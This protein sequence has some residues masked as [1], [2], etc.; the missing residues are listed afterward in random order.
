MAHSRNSY[1]SFCHRKCYTK[2]KFKA[3]S[4]LV[5][6]SFPDPSLP[7]FSLAQFK[8]KRENEPK[9]GVEV[10]LKVLRC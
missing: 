3:A 4:L 5:R 2:P 6:Y 8:Y 10:D 7:E 1:C 9:G